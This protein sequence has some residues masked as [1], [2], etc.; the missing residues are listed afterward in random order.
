MY[1]AALGGTESYE[2]F[3]PAVEWDTA[4]YSS[5]LVFFVSRDRVFRL[6]IPTAAA[7]CLVSVENPEHLFCRIAAIY[8]LSSTDVFFAVLTEQ[9]AENRVPANCCTEM[10]PPTAEFPRVEYFVYS[11]LTDRSYSLGSAWNTE[12]FAGVLEF[13]TQPSSAAIGLERRVNQQV[14]ENIRALYEP[15]K[16]ADLGAA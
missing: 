8:P 12:I 2:Y 3:R 6:Y 5:K 10:Q 16:A 15:L 11:S 7:D 9:K 14:L 1:A 13:D 4:V